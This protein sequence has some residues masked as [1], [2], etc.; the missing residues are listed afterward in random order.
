MGIID[1]LGD[2]I[3]SYLN[4]DLEDPVVFSN[5]RSFQNRHRAYED[6]DM[7]AAF[8]ELDEYLQGRPKQKKGAA[9]HTGNF[10]RPSSPGGFVASDFERYA[11]AEV[12]ESLKQDFAELGVPVGAS[13]E[14]CKSAYKKLLKIHHP[15]RHAGHPGNMKKATA[16]SARINAAF[17][18]IERWR[19]TG[20]A[21]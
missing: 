15:D 16:K 11:P 8:E 21:D 7:E 1:R 19:K 6:P 5:E 2:V 20:Q 12:P 13:S 9:S 14:D 17:D 3:K 18:R 10:H 4:D